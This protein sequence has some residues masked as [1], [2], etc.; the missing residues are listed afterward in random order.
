MLE[1]A[2]KMH[3]SKIKVKHAGHLNSEVNLNEFPL[4]YELCKSRLDLNLYQKY[5]AHRRELYGIDYVKPTE[6]VIYLN[7]S[8]FTDEGIFKFRNL[9]KGGFCTL[10]TSLKV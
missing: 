9:R 7:D 3:S 5:L 4:V 6:E 1:F 8:S 10:L 2:E